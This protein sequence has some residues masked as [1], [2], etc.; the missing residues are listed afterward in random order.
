[1]ARAFLDDL[2][3]RI[4]R[5]YEPGKVSLRELPERFGVS[6]EYAR[7]IRKQH[8]R[9]GQMERVR[10]R[11]HG[12][13]SRVTAELQQMIHTQVRAHPDRTLWKWQRRLQ[14]HKQI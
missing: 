6:W 5:A 3:C 2:R 9:Y 8:L 11:R 1:M 12:P 13:V 4:L 10:Q 14:K 7:N